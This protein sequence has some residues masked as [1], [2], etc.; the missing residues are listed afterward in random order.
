[1]NEE[2]LKLY[3][4]YNV[5][6]AADDTVAL[7]RL[8]APDFTLTHMTGYVQP[9]AEW[10]GEL[11]RGTMRYFSS[12]EDHVDVTV[13]AN[14]WRVV[15]QNRVVATIHGSSKNEWP[16]NTDMTVQRRNGTLQIM[17]AVVTTY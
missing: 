11:Q 7:N 10:L 8:L 2:I 3:R 14:G 5:A 16:L 13:T 12:V 4:T 1:M 9:R 15:G 6:M 17:A